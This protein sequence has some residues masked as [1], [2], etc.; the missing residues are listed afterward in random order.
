M[1]IFIL[2]LYYSINSAWNCAKGKQLFPILSSPWWL[3]PPGAPG[4][5]SRVSDS[6]SSWWPFVLSYPFSFFIPF[7][8][9]CSW[10]PFDHRVLYFLKGFLVI[11]NYEFLTTVPIYCFKKYLVSNVSDTVLGVGI[12][13]KN[14]VGQTIPSPVDFAVLEEWADNK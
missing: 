4:V 13:S 9:V 6:Q 12:T 7:K 10:Y 2:S 3:L 11:T 1:G 8:S 5:T 14:K